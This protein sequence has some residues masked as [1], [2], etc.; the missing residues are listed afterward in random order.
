[1]SGIESP[2]RNV[3]ALDAGYS[4]E[5]Q[6]IM[7]TE[8]VGARVLAVS[9]LRRIALATD[10]PDAVRVYRNARHALWIDHGI[11]IVKVGL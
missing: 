8:T 4:H 5:R 6:P 1:M 7:A 3:R 11:D 9:Q 10:N 2:A